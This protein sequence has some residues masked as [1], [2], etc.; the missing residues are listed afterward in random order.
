MGAPMEPYDNSLPRI[1][2]DK[3]ETFSHIVTDHVPRTL[4]TVE[5]NYCSN[6]NTWD[7]QRGQ[8]Y[9]P[10]IPYIQPDMDALKS[11]Y[12]PRQFDFEGGARSGHKLQYAKNK[13][14]R[15][16]SQEDFPMTRC[17]DSA[18]DFLDMN[19]KADNWFLQLECF[20]PHEPF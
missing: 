1:L 6:F 12:D 2:R 14:F 18:L 17:F 16:K 20:D 4:K 10:W 7:F 8:E 9:D 15:M 13:C 3:K 5:S 19:R 11:Q